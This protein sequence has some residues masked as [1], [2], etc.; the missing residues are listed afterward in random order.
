MSD[1]FSKKCTKCLQFRQVA[2]GKFSARKCVRRGG[3]NVLAKF[4]E[5]TCEK[6]V[7]EAKA[8]ANT[9]A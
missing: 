4:G 1:F 5:F 9:A 7:R 8:C 6:C 3:R 2:G